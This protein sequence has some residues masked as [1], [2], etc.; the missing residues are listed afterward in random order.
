MNL[1][2]RPQAVIGLLAAGVVLILPAHAD[3][4]RGM[5]VAS[6]L[7][8]LFKIICLVCALC[9]VVYIRGERLAHHAEYIAL[10][11]FATIGVMLMVSSQ[12][13]LMIFIGLEL[14]S[15]PLYVMTAFNKTD[16]RGAEVGLK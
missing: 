10:L 16:R 5:L 4:F 2:L 7:N 11:L 15:L 14:T 6:P 12:E 1:G 9:T 13:L 3:L 8:A